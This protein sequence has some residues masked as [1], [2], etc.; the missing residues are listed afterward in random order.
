MSH[1]SRAA[2]STTSTAVAAGQV[3]HSGAQ[4][5]RASPRA[6][7]HVT[8]GVVGPTATRPRSSRRD[9]RHVW[10]VA[11]CVSSR[12]CRA[13]R[14]RTVCNMQKSYIPQLRC[15]HAAQAARP[16]SLFENDP[17]RARLP[18]PRSRISRH[19]A[20]S[21]A[22]GAGAW[23]VRAGEATAN[24]NDSNRRH[25]EARRGTAGHS[26]ELKTGTREPHT[27]RRLYRCR[28]RLSR[29][30]AHTLTCHHML[31]RSLRDAR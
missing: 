4:R 5:L 29:L 21:R 9:V 28:S 20:V 18:L 22:R 14:E 30:S 11:V 23:R 7:A 6:H 15:Q 26:A 8:C 24:N 13:T 1:D 27:H 25:R 31:Q 19:P 10:C 17:A 12:T 16:P 3:A 2:P